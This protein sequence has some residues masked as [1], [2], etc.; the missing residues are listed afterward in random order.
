MQSSVTDPSF[1]LA[2]AALKSV[3]LEVGDGDEST[4]VADVDSVGVRHREQSLV[5][6][7]GRSVCNLT[8]PLHLAKPQS[9]VTEGRR[10]MNTLR[11]HIWNLTNTPHCHKLMH[12]A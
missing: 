5:E 7:L 4:D 10:K 6:K 12:S 2:A 11:K 9:T 1:V 3:G 8:V